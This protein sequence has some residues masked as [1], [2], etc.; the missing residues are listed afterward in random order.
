MY[1]IFF[2]M[3]RGLMREEELRKGGTKAS[4]GHVEGRWGWGEK[5]LGQRG[6]ES[7][8]EKSESIQDLFNTFKSINISSRL[9]KSVEILR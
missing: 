6:H 4:H 8:K 9:L 3:R 7:K 1:S 2:S 5:S